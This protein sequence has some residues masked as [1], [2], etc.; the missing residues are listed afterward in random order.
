MVR[1]KKLSC[2]VLASCVLVSL[3]GCSIPFIN[4][5][6]KKAAK[7]LTPEISVTDWEG[8][9][10]EGMEVTYVCSREIYMNSTRDKSDTLYEYDGYGRQTGII[11]DSFSGDSESHVIYNDDG[12]IAERSFADKRTSGYRPKNYTFTYTYNDKGQLASYNAV[13]I[14]PYGDRARDEESGEFVY[15]NGHLVS[16]GENEYDYNFDTLPYYEYV[17]EVNEDSDNVFK[18]AKYYY[19]ENNVL[20]AKEIKDNRTDYQYE[21]GVLTGWVLTYSMGTQYVYDAEGN[22]LCVLDA[23]GNTSQSWTYNDRGDVITH[24]IFNI[25]GLTGSASTYTYDYEYDSDGNKVKVT[26]E[27]RRERDGKETVSTYETTYEYEEHGLLISEVHM[28]GKRFLHMT[29]YSY[30]AILVPQA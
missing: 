17:V 29:V 4:I 13:F 9:V 24:E 3:S 19:D 1:I 26:E 2:A 21:D 12:T 10:P 22:S 23:D 18:I 30:E 25:A 8:D 5:S 15:E 7:E 28:S 16:D 6:A 27:Y 14:E 20:T 11:E